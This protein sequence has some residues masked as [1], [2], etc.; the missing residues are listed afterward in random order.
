M[1]KEK[2]YD[3]ELDEFLDYLETLEREEVAQLVESLDNMIKEELQ[4]QQ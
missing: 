4:D 3:M 1:K 2:L